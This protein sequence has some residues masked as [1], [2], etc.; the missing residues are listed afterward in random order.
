MLNAVSCNIEINLLLESF[1]GLCVA[2]YDRV[3]GSEKLTISLIFVL[4]LDA[5]RFHLLVNV[6]FLHLIE[7]HDG[8]KS[9]QISLDIK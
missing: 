2:F 5:L 1:M 7:L 9:I 8:S 3:M 4:K 6:T